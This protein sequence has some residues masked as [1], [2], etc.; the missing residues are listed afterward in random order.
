MRNYCANIDRGKLLF[1]H[2]FLCEKKNCSSG[3]ALLSEEMSACKKQSQQILFLKGGVFPS[4]KRKS[5]LKWQIHETNIQDKLC[6]IYKAFCLYPRLRTRSPALPA[7]FR[8]FVALALAHQIEPA[9]Q[10]KTNNDN[11]YREKYAHESGNG[12]FFLIDFVCSVRGWRCQRQGC[13]KHL[14][15]IFIVCYCYLYSIF[16]CVWISMIRL[17]GG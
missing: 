8:S 3:T 15:Y 10:N 1:E 2:I 12:S 13:L 5:C 17:L 14:S 7:L 9:Q 11:G 16:S 6:V 4:D